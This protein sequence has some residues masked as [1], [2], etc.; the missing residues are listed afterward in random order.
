MLIKNEIR[1]YATP[2]VKGLSDCSEYATKS[3][4]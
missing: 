3:L 4:G 2:A 1:I